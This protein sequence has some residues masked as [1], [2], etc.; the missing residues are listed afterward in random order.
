MLPVLG[1]AGL[2]LAGLFAVMVLCTGIFDNPPLD[3]RVD[4]ASQPWHLAF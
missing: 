3:R 1:L 4:D 2:G